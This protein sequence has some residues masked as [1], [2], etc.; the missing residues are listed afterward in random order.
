MTDPFVSASA[1]LFSSVL[2]ETI[3]F[4]PQVGAPIDISGVRIDEP[5]DSLDGRSLR[6]IS[7]DIAALDLARPPAK[8]DALRDADGVTWMV[9]QVARVDRATW[10]LHV[11][12]KTR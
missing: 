8:E 7:F 2:A 4:V 9:V 11:E 1:A 10:R 5:S 12:K 3:S 6:K